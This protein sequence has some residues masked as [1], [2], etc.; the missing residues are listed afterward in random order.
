MADLKIINEL[1]AKPVYIT[2]SAG[3]CTVEIREK[4][5]VT[6]SIKLTDRALYIAKNEGRNR[7]VVTDLE[8]NE[9]CLS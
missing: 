2:I 6:D 4:K 1:S 7:V 9:L 5:D 3:V 8:E